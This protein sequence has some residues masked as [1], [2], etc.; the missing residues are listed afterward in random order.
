MSIYQQSV[1][2]VRSMEVRGAH[3]P[4]TWGLNTTP[5]CDWFAWIIN[6]EYSVDMC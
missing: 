1:L 5:C 2:G 4:L 3:D 6:L